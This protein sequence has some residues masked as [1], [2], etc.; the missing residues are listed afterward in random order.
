VELGEVV[1]DLP[2]RA[3]RPP[4]EPARYDY[5]PINA[6]PRDVG[7]ATEASA[8][9]LD[10]PRWPSRS[11]VVAMMS[12]RAV[13]G[14]AAAGLADVKLIADVLP[15]AS[16][17]GGAAVVLIVVLATLLAVYN[18]VACKAAIPNKSES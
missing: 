4:P 2:V 16:L 13:V 10:Q 14:L 18:A 1:V 15:S 6:P 7:A 12:L 11:I 3:P 5:L 17:L 9:E 8:A